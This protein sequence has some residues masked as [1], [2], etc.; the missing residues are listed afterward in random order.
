[1]LAVEFW[2]LKSSYL[3][4]IKFGEGCAICPLFVEAIQ[5]FELLLNYICHRRKVLRV[6]ICKFNH[7][8]A[9]SSKA[10]ALASKC[11]F[12]RSEES[13]PLKMLLNYDQP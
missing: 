6:H 10:L 5:F 13:V 1:M 9:S 3:E 11:G 4:G 7:S 8:Y 2:K 12:A